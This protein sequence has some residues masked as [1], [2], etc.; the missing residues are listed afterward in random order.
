MSRYK[1]AVLGAGFIGPLHLDALSR[2]PQADPVAV[3]DVNERV[4]NALAE[5][6]GLRACRDWRQV[7]A[8][9]EIEVIHNCLPVGL[10]DE[11]NRAALEAG[12][13]IYCEKPLSLTAAGAREIALLA[14]EKGIPVAL[15]HQYRMNA[16]VQEARAMVAKGLAGRVLAISGCYLQESGSRP[17]DWSSRM[18][19]TGVTRAVSDIGTHW[20]DTA[21]CV[22]G[23]PIAEVMADLRIHYPVRTDERGGTH[24]METED[25]GFILLRFADGTPGQLAVSKA[26]NGH[27]NDLRVAVWGSEYSV[28]WRQEQPDRLLIG[29]KGS[30][31]TETRYMNPRDCQPETL[32]LITAPM[33]H[34]MG[35]PDALRNAMQAY[36][37]ALDSGTWRSGGARYATFR[38]GF[39]HM[40]FVEACARS[41]RERRWVEVEKL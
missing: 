16:A 25:T 11:V 22:L 20:A 21:A 3:C 23:Q 17:D 26:A 38:D 15:N 1:V 33:G 6:Y 14:E 29:H 10:H 18:E 31:G 12:K 5:R 8:D 37:D 36:Y 35:W 9:P 39:A 4:L 34:V 7:I 41:S 24:P 13:K 28:E 27:K 30:R 40:A 32:P 2:V 19:N